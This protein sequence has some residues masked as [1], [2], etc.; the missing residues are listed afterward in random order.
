MFK[1]AVTS[2]QAATL[3]DMRGLQALSRVDASLVPQV[4]RRK[5]KTKRN[6]K[7]KLIVWAQ[8]VNAVLDE[9]CGASVSYAS[10][11][12]KLQCDAQDMRRLAGSWASFVS[13]A[14]GRALSAEDMAA[15]MQNAGLTAELVG[16]AKSGVLGALWA[17]RAEVRARMAAQPS[18]TPY[19]KDFDWK[20]NLTLSSDKA[21]SLN[22]PV[23]LL[24]LNVVQPKGVGAGGDGAGEKHVVEL[25]QPDLAKL[26]AQL[27]AMNAA[28]TA[29]E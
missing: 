18:C 22:T 1:C 11:A 3:S 14:F 27:E 16:D 13:L 28:M 20:L 4:R 24:S 17:R 12:S 23:V 19:L 6:A 21:A 26:V 5:K 25:T 9:L 29:K 15:D 10:F 7:Q 2:Q 8:F